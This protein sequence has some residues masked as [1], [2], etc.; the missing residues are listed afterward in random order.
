M[1]KWVQYHTMNELFQIKIQMF[2][3]WRSV[4]M[5]NW[6]VWSENMS[7]NIDVHVYCLTI[8]RTSSVVCVHCTDKTVDLCSLWAGNHY[9]SFGLLGFWSMEQSCKTITFVGSYI[10]FIVQWKMCWKRAQV[11]VRGNS[12]QWYIHYVSI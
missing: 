6:Q 4:A 11:G 10:L 3:L 9:Q 12:N 5:H 7:R 1:C 8:D 2:T